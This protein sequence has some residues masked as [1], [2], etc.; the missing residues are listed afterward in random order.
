MLH[1]TS[2]QNDLSSKEISKHLIW[3]I[4]IVSDPSSNPMMHNFLG[5][6]DTLW[7]SCNKWSKIF[8]MSDHF[9]R[10][11]VKELKFIG[12]LYNIEISDYFQKMKIFHKCFWQN[13]NNVEDQND[14]EPKIW[15]KFVN[16]VNFKCCK[17]SEVSHRFFTVEWKNFP[18]K[19][20]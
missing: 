11:Y 14:L 12:H 15:H 1:V 4:W 9:G 20:T 6:A 17:S 2:S 8:K 13:F 3:F 16:L 7:K 19:G 10:L 5:W 18:G